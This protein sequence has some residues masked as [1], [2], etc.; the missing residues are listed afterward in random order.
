[1][2][3]KTTKTIACLLAGLTL[4]ACMEKDKNLTTADYPDHP[5]RQ[6]AE[7]NALYADCFSDANC[8]AFYP[9]NINIAP[10]TDTNGRAVYRGTISGAYFV[11]STQYDTYSQQASFHVNFGARTVSYQGVIA[12]SDVDVTATYNARGIMT[13]SY[14]TGSRPG[15]II[16]LVGET[17]LIGS[18]ALN[19]G[20]SA[21]G[22][23]GLRQ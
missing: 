14:R 20:D 13:G 22:F 2:K 21:G 4:S 7:G 3:N 10:L 5:N 12:G 9:S 15:R 8:I 19:N 11:N 16:G 6:F 23:R 1:M 18:F 17:E